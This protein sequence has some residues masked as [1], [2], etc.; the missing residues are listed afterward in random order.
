MTK[1]EEV[2]KNA[3]MEVETSEIKEES[4]ENLADI[5]DTTPRDI[6][7]VDQEEDN[8]TSEKDETNTTTEQKDEKINT[9]LEQEVSVSADQV[10]FVEKD[11]T[12]TT[13]EQLLISEVSPE[14][15]IAGVTSYDSEE[16]AVARPMVYDGATHGLHLPTNIHDM[17][18]AC[19]PTDNSLSKEE[20]YEPIMHPPIQQSCNSL[21][22]LKNS[23]KDVTPP[24]I[25]E[26]AIQN[27]DFLSP[28]E[29]TLNLLKSD[30]NNYDPPSAYPMSNEIANFQCTDIHDQ[31]IDGLYNDDDEVSY[32]HFETSG[33]EEVTSLSTAT[34]AQT[35]K[36]PILH[37]SNFKP[38]SG[39]T[40]ASDFT[41]RCFVARLRAGITAVKHGRSRW[42]KSR[43]RVF[44]IDDGTTLRWK[45][46]IGEPNSRKNKPTKLDLSHCLEVRHAWETDPQNPM[47]TG[48]VTLRKKCEAANA[49]KSFALIFPQRT[50]DVTAITADQCQVLME[51]FSALCFRLQVANAGNRKRDADTETD[52]TKSTINPASID[53]RQQRVT[54]S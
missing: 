12:T 21:A 28:K 31:I 37:L 16:C 23:E 54:T 2:K 19:Q 6:K 36:M 27:D 32:Q 34:A 53:F 3:T 8:Q 25:Q 41:I 46:A 22:M 10:M 52:T 13:A 15:E 29:E 45:A 49:H 50:V 4:Q 9:E 18:A 35:N 1:I 5:T 40:N 20:E 51:G 38:A 48:T 26:E 11:K 14:E 42:C 44:H 43:L 33:A 30:N 24:A 7:D 47:F 39:C 17:E